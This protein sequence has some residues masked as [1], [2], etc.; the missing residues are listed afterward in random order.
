LHA[1]H[2]REFT[3]PARA[4]LRLI[5][6]AVLPALGQSVPLRSVNDSE[7]ALESLFR[8][9][10]SARAKPYYLHQPDPAPGTSRFHVPIEEKQRLLRG[11][12][13]VS[14]VLPG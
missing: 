12:R 7:V 11:L 6:S 13:G 10:L 14:P 5:Q 9:L 3:S 4:A 1:N 2:A 8:A